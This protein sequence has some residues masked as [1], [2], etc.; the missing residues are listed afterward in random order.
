VRVSECALGAKCGMCQGETG[1]VC[2][3]AVHGSSGELIVELHFHKLATNKKEWPIV[4]GQQRTHA[5]EVRF[6][7]ARLA[8]TSN[9]V[10]CYNERCQVGDAP[11]LRSTSRT[12]KHTNLHELKKLDNYP[13]RNFQV[14]RRHYIRR[15]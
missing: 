12:T 10:W 9:S 6:A 8:L 2:V 1:H 4:L 15:G 14:L 7:V 13:R 3:A 5:H 11:R